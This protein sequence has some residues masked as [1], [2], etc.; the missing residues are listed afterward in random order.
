MFVSKRGQAFVSRIGSLSKIANALC[1]IFA[2]VGEKVVDYYENFVN[3]GNILTVFNVSTGH[4]FVRIQVTL[5]SNI[6]ESQMRIKIGT[7]IKC[8]VTRMRPPVQLQAHRASFLHAA[9]SVQWECEPAL[10]T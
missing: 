6:C 7:V 3:S 8:L 2:G 4:T 9:S 10:S 5:L 1:I